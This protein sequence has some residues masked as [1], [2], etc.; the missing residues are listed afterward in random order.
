MRLLRVGEPDNGPPSN[1]GEA[2]PPPAPGERAG[3]QTRRAPANP[4]KRK[5]VAREVCLELGEEPVIGGQALRQMFARTEPAAPE[6]EYFPPL[7][8][9]GETIGTPPGSEGLAGLHHQGARAR[10]RSASRGDW[11]KGERHTLVAS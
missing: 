6:Q 1:Q 8:A 4:P 9:S 5:L 10:S 7:P 2:V 11:R 3:R